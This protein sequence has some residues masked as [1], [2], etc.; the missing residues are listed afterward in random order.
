M[1]TWRDVDIPCLGHIERL[2]G[3]SVPVGNRVAVISY[4]ALHVIDLTARRIIERD[5]TVAEGGD[6]YDAQTQTLHHKGISYPILGVHGGSRAL[7]T[8][9]LGERLAFDTSID[10]PG[11]I[12]RVL[13]VL[14]AD[15]QAPIDIHFDDFS[16]DW[17]H[18][19]FSPDGR[20]IVVGA[21]YDLLVL[22][23]DQVMDTSGTSHWT[24]S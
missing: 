6:A 13:H 7:L 20:F 2:T 21:P 3:F 24:E 5:E 22:Q 12:V 16:G 18:A 11:S 15:N 1:A 14:D 19:T 9:P 17:C 23:R 10:G 4:E 8:N